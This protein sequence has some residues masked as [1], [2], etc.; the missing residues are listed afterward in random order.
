MI[1]EF[2]CVVSLPN[3]DLF[4]FGKNKIL[5]LLDAENPMNHTTTSVYLNIDPHSSNGTV[6]CASLKYC[7][8]QGQCLMIGNQLKCL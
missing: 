7:H 5:L 3:S 8:Q 4:L 2:T 6:A 1:L